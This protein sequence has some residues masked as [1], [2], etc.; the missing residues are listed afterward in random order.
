MANLR[1]QNY[2]F[3]EAELQRTLGGKLPDQF[4]KDYIAS[5]TNSQAL[6]D[7]IDKNTVDIEQLFL[8]LAATDDALAAL[9]IR[10]TTAEGEI[11]TL[12]IDLTNHIAAQSAHGASGD[13]VGNLDYAAASTGGV[14][15]LATAV[16]DA[17]DSATTPP[18]SVGAAPAAYNQT[19]EQTQADAINDLIG[20]V[21]DLQ[22]ALN[23]AIDVINS[24]L[25]TERTA[26]QR[27]V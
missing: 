12:Q 17:V 8:D 7:A 10:V 23:S 27:A 11:D 20:N 6:L 25:A 24:S 9:T 2:I 19:Y 22:N 15:W 5:K 21:I 4:I 14:V 1:L 16:G 3:T 18:S 26:K 13:V